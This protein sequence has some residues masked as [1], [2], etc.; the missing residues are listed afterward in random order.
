MSDKKSTGCIF[1]DL[2]PKPLLAQ[3][4]QE[5]VSSDGGAVLL[6]AAERNLG[7]IECLG[8]ALHDNR[9][10]GKVKHDLQELLAQRVYAIACGYPDG[11]DAARLADDPVHKLLV[12]R[13]SKDDDALASQSTISRFENSVDSKD[14]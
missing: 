11:N 2:F 5:R 6:K 8:E 7:I 14:I 4:D 1:Q 3:F 13:C 9:Q 10:Q 12:G